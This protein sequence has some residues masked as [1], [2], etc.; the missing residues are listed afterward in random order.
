MDLPHQESLLPDVVNLERRGENGRAREALVHIP[1]TDALDANGN[2]IEDAYRV[3][4]GA[5]PISRY[6]GDKYIQSYEPRYKTEKVKH[7]YE[8]DDHGNWIKRKTFAL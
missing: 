8:L 6:D 1:I 2:S 5:T 4:D 3:R 7:E